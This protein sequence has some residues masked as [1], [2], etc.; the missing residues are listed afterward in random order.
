MSLDGISLEPSLDIRS[1]CIETPII[2]ELEHEIETALHCKDLLSRD[3]LLEFSS[4]NL[5]AFREHSSSY[6]H[7]EPTEEFENLV[8]IFT[9]FGGQIVFGPSEEEFEENPS[10]FRCDIKATDLVFPIC[11]EGVNR[12]QIMYLVLCC[13]KRVLIHNAEENSNVDSDDK[14]ESKPASLGVV[15]PHGAGIF[16]ILS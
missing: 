6:L 11:H 5:A 12:S 7:R 14:I 8:N 10:C 16:F 2:R 4:E 9:D 1:A 15:L 13:I 3:F